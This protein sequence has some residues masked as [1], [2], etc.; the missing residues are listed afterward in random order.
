MSDRTSLPYAAAAQLFFH[1]ERRRAPGVAASN[2]AP[3][4]AR[5]GRRRFKLDGHDVGNGG[6]HGRHR[7]C[8]QSLPAQRRDFA[9][10]TEHGQAVA[11]IRGQSDFDHRVVEPQA[12]HQRHARRGAG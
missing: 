8:F 3:R 7:R 11:S 9:R 2:D 4:V 12:G 6:R 5:T 1:P 10:E